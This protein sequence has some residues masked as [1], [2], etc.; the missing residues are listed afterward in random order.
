MC[1]N[2]FKSRIEMRQEWIK[3]LGYSTFIH[4]IQEDP[5]HKLKR[6]L[7]LL[8]HYRS[9]ASQHDYLLLMPKMVVPPAERTPVI[10]HELLLKIQKV[11]PLP[12]KDAH[13]KPAAPWEKTWIEDAD[14]EEEE[15]EEEGNT[16]A[17]I[18]KR[19]KL[20]DQMLWDTV[21]S[22]CPE[23]LESQT[24][25]T[26]QP[27]SQGVIYQR[28][29][30]HIDPGN[31][32]DGDDDDDDDDENDG[33]NGNDDAYNVGGKSNDEK[34]ACGR[35]EEQSGLELLRHSESMDLGYEAE[36][37]Y[38]DEKELTW[39]EVLGTWRI[40]QLQLSAPGQPE[41]QPAALNHLIEGWR[42]LIQA[43]DAIE[44]IKNH[45]GILSMHLEIAL[46]ALFAL[47]W[48]RHHEVFFHP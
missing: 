13:L 30:F 25:L 12:P 15:E 40:L 38:E 43:I 14:E 29:A 34:G 8:T 37:E 21:S 2:C 27:S 39:E 17:S 6:I 4:H 18:Q 46:M 22:T 1:Q 36:D 44:E 3:K 20:A 23:C 35:V 32:A 48:G 24:K 47:D 45:F 26:A 7:N 28:P 10:P 16:L 42:Y 9:H 31:E 11:P 19:I 41:K 5:R 33:D